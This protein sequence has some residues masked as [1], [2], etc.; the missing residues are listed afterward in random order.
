MGPCASSCT[1]LCLILHASG[2]I[3]HPHRTIHC[4]HR[5]QEVARKQRVKRARWS[6]PAAAVIKCSISCAHEQRKGVACK[7][8]SSWQMMRSQAAS[9]I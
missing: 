3:S 2:L 1:N 4:M 7:N 8:C 6:V 5:E 9:F